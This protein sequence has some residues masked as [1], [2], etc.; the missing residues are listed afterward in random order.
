MTQRYITFP[1]YSHFL[2]K[3]YK[4]HLYS[5]LCQ[6]K[7][8]ELYTLL[9]GMTPK[10]VCSA[11]CHTDTIDHCSCPKAK[12]PAEIPLLQEGTMGWWYPSRKELVDEDSSTRGRKSGKIIWKGDWKVFRESF[13][14]RIWR[15]NDAK[16]KWILLWRWQN[17]KE[18][19]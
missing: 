19:D 2:T 1:F 10:H 9:P 14:R 12:A 16:Q 18:R 6:H 17:S 7:V 15:K 3:K 5:L 13:L 11:N 8:R 4:C